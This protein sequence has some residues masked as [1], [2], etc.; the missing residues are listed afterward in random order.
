MKE[1]ELARIREEKRKA[2]EAQDVAKEQ[3]WTMREL[4]W[5]EA[6][7]EKNPRNDR[8]LRSLLALLKR[9]ERKAKREGDFSAVEIYREKEEKIARRLIQIKP[10]DQTILLDLIRR[11][12]RQIARAKEQGDIETE[13]KYEEQKRE[14]QKRRQT[15][16]NRRAKKESIRE[17]LAK[18]PK[19]EKSAVEKARALIYEGE[20]IIQMAEEIK[21]LMQGE[22]EENLQFLLAELYYHTGFTQRAQKSL[23]AYKKELSKAG[24]NVKLVN[25]GLAVAMNSRSAKINWDEFWRKKAELER[26][27]QAPELEQ[28]K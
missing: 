27:R 9:Q 4:A 18:Y 1:S 16:G 24:E 26:K 17:V 28:Q 2:I 11:S 13:R 10:D 6:S 5:L 15:K 22:T 23:K 3:E 8:K 20:D 19:P 7:V 21:E 25:L 14:W 12:N